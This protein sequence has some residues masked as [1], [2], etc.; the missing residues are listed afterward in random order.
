MKKIRI[1]VV[2][3]KGRMGS[4]IIDCILQTK[5]AVLSGAIANDRRCEDIGLIFGKTIGIN[6][7]NSLVELFN[8]ADVV[9]EFTNSDTMQ[10]CINMA[11]HT[12]TPLVSGTTGHD[13]H[14]LLLESAQHVPILWSA[15]MSIGINMLTKLV[16]ES[17]RKLGEEYDIEILEMH[18]AQKQDAPSG[19]A[20]MLGE[21][22]AEGRSVDL[23]A[24]KTT[25][26]AGIRKKGEIGFASLRG[27]GVFGEHNVM[28][29]TED[30]YIS[31]RHVSLTRYLFAKGAVKAAL[32]LHN[33]KNNLYSMQD[34][35]DEQ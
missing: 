19:T 33:Q 13:H 3:Y 1:A 17:A 8:Q 5:S 28:F 10:E 22:A 2:G 14:K 24:V 23:S 4:N 11:A 31:L 26:R 9:I 18:H 34:V 12:N 20:L 35:L 30:E 25:D 29:A 7:S 27:G 15:N 21:A 6:S 16:K 32:W